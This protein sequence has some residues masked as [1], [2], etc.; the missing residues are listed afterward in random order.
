MEDLV[1]MVESVSVAWDV[2]TTL[3]VLRRI[4]PN[5]L[6]TIGSGCRSEY[7]DKEDD[8]GGGG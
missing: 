4:H 8:E 3:L 1:S 7:K 6:E 2:V 5:H